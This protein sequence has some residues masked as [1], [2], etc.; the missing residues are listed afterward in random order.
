ML[1]QPARLQPARLPPRSTHH[2]TSMHYSENNAANAFRTH[3]TPELLNNF[4]KAMFI[5]H[6]YCNTA[7]VVPSVWHQRC[8]NPVISW[9]V[10]FSN[11]RWFSGYFC[12]RGRR[13]TNIR[14][15]TLPEI[16]Q[17]PLRISLDT[18]SKYIILNCALDQ[19]F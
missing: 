8:R 5:E 13:G 10:I 9:L 19:R 16:L 6:F 11:T 7:E 3:K 12:T 1:D 15:A 18:S 17:F 14:V 2:F 4:A